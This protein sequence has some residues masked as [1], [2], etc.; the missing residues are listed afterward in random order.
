MLQWSSIHGGFF[1]R[2]RHIILCISF[3]STIKRIFIAISRFLLQYS[4]LNVAL[5]GCI[6]IVWNC[7]CF[8]YQ[9]FRLSLSLPQ[10]TLKSSRRSHFCPETCIVYEIGY[11][12]RKWVD[13]VWESRRGNLFYKLWHL[14]KYIVYIDFNPYSNK[15]L[16]FSQI[17]RVFLFNI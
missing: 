7:E 11:P 6:N 12:Q 13:Y 1:R 3:N 5:N 4:A 16:G 15:K 10:S 14:R 9:Q 8:L 17:P 2:W